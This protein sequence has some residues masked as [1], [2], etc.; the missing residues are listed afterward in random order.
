MASGDSLC[1]LFALNYTPATTNYATFTVRTGRRNLEFDGATNETAIWEDIMPSWY[2]GGGVDVLIWWWS[3]STSQDLDWDVAF[4]RVDVT[5]DIGSDGF[6]AVNSADGETS[7]AT[8]ELLTKT[9][10]QFTDGADMDSV[11]AN[12]IFRMK[13][14]RDAANDGSTV[15][16][17]VYAVHIKEA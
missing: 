15:D 3:F 6:A 12:D 4:E 5:Q 9:T 2:A 14:I 17:I 13:L 7:N 1:R 11:V 10:I 8:A 16:A